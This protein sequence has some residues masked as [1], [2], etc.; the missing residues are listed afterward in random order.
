MFKPSEVFL[1]NAS[2][3]GATPSSEASE[4]RIS[5]TRSLEKASRPAYFVHLPQKIRDGVLG[6][7]GQGR[8]VG[9]VEIGPVP[10]DGKLIPQGREIRRNR[11]LLFVHPF[12]PVR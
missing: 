10:G 9:E 6:A 7:P 12:S 2:V 5:S 11:R 1:M 8:L 4:K 3:P